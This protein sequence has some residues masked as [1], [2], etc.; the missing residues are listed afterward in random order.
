VPASSVLSSSAA[1]EG[2]VDVICVSLPFRAP[3]ERSV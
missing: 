2:D 1:G 3:R